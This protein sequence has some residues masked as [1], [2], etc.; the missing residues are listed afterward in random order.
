L[1]SPRIVE[2]T[3]TCCTRE[4]PCIPAGCF[5]VDIGPA[6]SAQYR[7]VLAGCNTLLWN[8]PMGK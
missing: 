1:Q 8:G 4:A 3:T 2:L 5:G 6:S 7:S